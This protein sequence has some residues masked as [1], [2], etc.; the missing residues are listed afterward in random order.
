[1]SDAFRYDGKRVLV[2]GGATGIGAATAQMATGLGAEVIVMDVAEINFPARQAIKV[3]LRDKASVDAA[4][5]QIDGDIHA[6]F[7]CAGVADGTRGIALINFIAQRHLI[8]RLVG[9]SRLKRGGAVAFI[10][11]VAGLGWN[12]NMA[13]LLEFVAQTEWEAAVGWLA[14][15]P[16]QENYTFTKQAVNAYIA[17]EALPLLKKGIRINGI[18]P[19]PTDTPLARANADTWLAFGKDYRAAA[20]VGTL[21]P[22]DMAGPLLF[23]C[24]D[25]ATGITGLSLLVDQ[26]HIPASITGAYDDPIIRGMMGL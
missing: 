24:S 14:Q 7:S 8:D 23:L 17:A 10:G 6:V 21:A 19:G 3:D 16:E 5:A 12:G 18:M 11:S 13:Q 9:T 15:H 22:M 20:D 1:M 4:I 26:G 25:A 2:V